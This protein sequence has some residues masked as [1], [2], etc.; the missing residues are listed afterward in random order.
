MNMKDKSYADDHHT[1]IAP[2]NIV[3]P[4]S[5]GKDILL[6]FHFLIRIK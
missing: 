6:L 4:E 2:S 5:V 1:F 3:L